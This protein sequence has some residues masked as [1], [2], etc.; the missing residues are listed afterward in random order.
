MTRIYVSLIVLALMCAAVVSCENEPSGEEK[1]LTGNVTADPI[2]WDGTKNAE[3]TYQLLVYSFADSDGDG[4]G[5]LRGII[6]KLDYLDS[7]G[8]TALWLSPVHP[9]MSYHGYDVLDYAGVNPEFGTME[10]F[11]ELVSAAHER[12]IKIYIDYVLN[13]SGSDHPWFLDA[14][15]SA[16]S[17]YRDFYTFSENPAADIEAGRI[18]MIASEGLNQYYAGN[19]SDLDVNAAASIPL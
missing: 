4:I 15:K 8:A 12:D 16:D 1:P 7:L 10:D 9:A 14:K 11:R 2:E 17:H 18:P 5:D 19:F 13:H 3:I 6:D